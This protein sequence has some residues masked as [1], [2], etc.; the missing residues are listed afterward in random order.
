M[1]KFKCGCGVIIGLSISPADEEKTLV[2]EAV[3]EKIGV[4]EFWF[5]LRKK[6]HTRRI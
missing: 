4:E 6:N 2:D 5:F 3:V 1:S